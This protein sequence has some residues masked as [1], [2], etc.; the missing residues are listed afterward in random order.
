MPYRQQ[1]LASR[2]FQ[3]AV[4]A[5]SF[6]QEIRD[7]A[8]GLNRRVEEAEDI[9]LDLIS[10]PGGVTRAF[11]KRRMGM[12]EAYIRIARDLGHDDYHA[13]LHSLKTLMSLSFHAK[14]VTMPMNT[15]R[16]Q[17]EIMKEAVKNIH[18]RRRQME[19]IADFST[20]S[21]GQPQ[22]IRRF[23]RELRRVETPES[24]RP[25]RE[26]DLG[27]DDH[28]HDNLSEGRK[29]PS[30]LILDA[31]IK[32]I[33]RLTLV[34]YD[35]P[36]RD[37]VREALEAGRILGV[38]VTIGVEFSVG[39]QRRRKHFLLVPP[40]EGTPHSFFDYFN[41]NCRYLSAFVEG[42]EENRRRRHRVIGEI[43]EQ[44]NTT[45]RVALNQA[46]GDDGM[47]L[48]PPIDVKDL[49]GYVP[50][51]QCSRFHLS[52]LVYDR[53]KS[54]LHRRV[55]YLKTQYEVGRQLRT[56]GQMS[57]W[58]LKRIESAYRSARGHYTDL[59]PGSL[60]ESYFSSKRIVDY[61]SAFPFEDHILPDLHESGGAIVFTSPL[62]HGLNVAVDT[63]IHCHASIDAIE[64]MNMR[65]NMER[66]PVEVTRLAGIVRAI[67]S[68]DA[69]EVRRLVL[70]WTS[71]TPDPDALAAAVRRY[72]QRPLQPLA[73]S[74]STGWTPG[75]PGMGFI[76]ASQIPARSRQSFT[77]TH[78]RLPRSVST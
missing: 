22:V 32:G 65:D 47:F 70:D 11:Y 44:F 24:D 12:A 17:I 23:L 42:L 52:E 49:E 9:T 63:L 39:A 37:I 15:A 10:H 41:L 27:W 45:H 34:Y 20:A 43:L 16:V 58:E 28:V 13:R 66:N 74:A 31:F 59:N 53:L 64:I 33:S 36:R 2:W 4:D 29:T 67:N 57:D 35:I 77:E 3:R 48:L 21:F 60:R 61:D 72:G 14:T 7:I 18:N 1:R 56:A 46:Y 54:V 38:A 50:S 5:L 40:Q 73:A 69:D 75:V 25:F 68:G 19:M 55:L 30:Q 51:G 78:Y 26:M 71:L 62:E 76:R 6:N 8:E